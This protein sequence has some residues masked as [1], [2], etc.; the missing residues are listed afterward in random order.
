MDLY[1]MPLNSDYIPSIEDAKKSI[2]AA[3]KRLHSELAHT[4]KI[5]EMIINK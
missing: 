4:N 5:Y 3:F 1:Y 2:K